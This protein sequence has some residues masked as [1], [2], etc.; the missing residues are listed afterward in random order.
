MRAHGA[1][2]AASR[3]RWPPGRFPHLVERAK[4]GLIMVLRDGRRFANEADSY[5]DLMQALFAAMPPGES[6]LAG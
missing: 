2:V 5:H 6:R 4:P 3:T 1:G